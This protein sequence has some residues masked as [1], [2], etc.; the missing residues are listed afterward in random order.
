M[1][2]FYNFLGLTNK[3]GKLSIGYNKSEEA[4]KGNKA[5]LIIICDQVSQNTIKKF[6]NYSERYKIKLIEGV[7]SEELEKIFVRKQPKIL[8]VLDGGM[9]RK[10]EELWQKECDDM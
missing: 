10:L 1:N 6:K 9:S 8:V 2:R 4:V 7:S 3:A 5:K